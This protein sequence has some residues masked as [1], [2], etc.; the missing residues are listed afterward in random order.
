MEQ[1]QTE[2]SLL[3]MRL[4]TR[5]QLAFFAF[6]LLLLVLAQ[7]DAAGRPNVVWIV[8][9]DMS[10]N[11]SCYGETAIQTPH[12]DRLAAEGVRFTRAYAL[13]CQAIYMWC[14]NG[15]LAI[16]REI[17]GHVIDHNPDHI[18]TSCCVRLSENQQQQKES[19]KSQLKTSKQSH[20]KQRPFGLSLLHWN[21]IA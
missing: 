12:V 15:C 8:V 5:L 2:R 1:A 21:K 18:W 4:F 10:P 14:L 7:A 19:K 9:D 20:V 6:F 11:F 17:R 3:N 13:G 16:T